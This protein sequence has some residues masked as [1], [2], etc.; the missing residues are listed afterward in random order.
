[1]SVFLDRVFGSCFRTWVWSNPETGQQKYIDYLPK[2]KWRYNDE[3]LMNDLNDN[4]SWDV[5][6]LTDDDHFVHSRTLKNMQLR[7]HDNVF[8]NPLNS[9][10][11]DNNSNNNKNN[12]N[13]DMDVPL[14]KEAE[15]NTEEEEIVVDTHV[16]QNVINSSQNCSTSSDNKALASNDTTHDI[17]NSGLVINKV[18]ETV[19]E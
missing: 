6:D 12:N 1:M 13:K 14:E 9:E 7:L 16:S 2:R 17:S 4:N 19:T 10:D 18:A 3:N 8:I 5:M 15:E 11:K